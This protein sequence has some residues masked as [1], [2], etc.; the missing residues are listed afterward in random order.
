M[1]INFGRIPTPTDWRDVKLSMGGNGGGE[2]DNLLQG[3]DITAP[4]PTTVKQKSTKKEQQKATTKATTQSQTTTANDI[5]QNIAKQN[6]SDPAL[7]AL[8][9][10][11]TGQDTDPLVA[12]KDVAAEG[13]IDWLQNLLANLNVEDAETRAGGR[14]AD[15]SRQL[16]EQVMPEIFGGAEMAGTGGNALAMLLAQDAAVRTGEAQNR[17][18]EEARNA[19]IAQGLQGAGTMGELTSGTSGL[20]QRLMAAL[21]IS[22]GA[23][24]TGQVATSERGTSRTAGTTT[25][26]QT[27]TQTGKATG[28][29]AET[30]PLGWAKL[31]AELKVAGA[32][33][34]SR[35]EKALA[36]FM[37]G[38]GDPAHL[39]YQPRDFGASVYANRLLSNIKANI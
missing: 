9:A 34:P 33:Q 5:I 4:P 25:E 36:T 19:A 28:E 13:N 22:K 23:V 3:I 31:L 6:I 35:N 2:L 29:T 27:G 16:R 38:G 1:A 10:I 30:D 21:D 37:A 11:I 17:A 12:A 18:I 26:T 15:L 7:A 39:A 8:N 20:T 24:E 14:T 32:N